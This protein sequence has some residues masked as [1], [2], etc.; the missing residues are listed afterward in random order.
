MAD[1]KETEAQQRELMRY[2]DD[3]A[4]AGRQ[5][6]INMADAEGNAMTRTLSSVLD[7]AANDEKA[8]AALEACNSE[9]AE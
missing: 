7:D 1:P 5:A 9:M 6:Q 4:K 3:E 8:A 2:L